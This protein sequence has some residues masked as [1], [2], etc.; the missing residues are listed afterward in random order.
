[1]TIDQAR[2]FIKQ[3]IELRR[4]FGK[5]LTTKDFDSYTLLEAL[6][7]LDDAGWADGD[8]AHAALREDRALANRQLGA[9]KAREARMTQQIQGYQTRIAE[10]EALVQK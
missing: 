6:V 8:A 3:V 9:A 10:L 4:K 2:E 5:Q 7:L 1:M